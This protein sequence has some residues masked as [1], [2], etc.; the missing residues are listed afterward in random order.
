MNHYLDIAQTLLLLALGVGF[1]RIQKHVVKGGR[2]TIVHNHSPI[3]L[4]DPANGM[5]KVP[6]K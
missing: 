6:E 4:R 5:P 2:T 1:L 3:P